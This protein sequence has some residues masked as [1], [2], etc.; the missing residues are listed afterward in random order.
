MS[1]KRP[2]TLTFF[3]DEEVTPRLFAEKIAR[4]CGG[5][6]LRPGEGI[7]VP[8]SEAA[9]FVTDETLSVPYFGNEWIPT[10]NKERRA[11]AARARTRKA[12]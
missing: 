10:R 6:A 11:R 5:S 4:A 2:V 8:G 3:L 7:L 1:K 12:P 9:C